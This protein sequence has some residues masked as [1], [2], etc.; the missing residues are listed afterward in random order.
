MIDERLEVAWRVAQQPV[1]VA[2][3]AGWAGLGLLV[4]AFI[5]GFRT[6][7]RA[8]VKA[9]AVLVAASAALVCLVVWQP[10]R[11]PPEDIM[12]VNQ[13]AANPEVMRDRP[14]RIYGNVACGS[15]DRGPGADDYQFK[16]QALGLL[17]DVVLEVRYVGTLPN[18]FRE[19][20]LVEA[21]GKL[22]ADGVFDV[23][24]DGIA[25]DS[26]AYSTPLHCAP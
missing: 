2:I 16:I 12:S 17:A 3:I 13:V 22:A 20:K 6:D 4:A 11:E 18:G 15:V 21:R 19:G 8:G 9:A 7:W 25:V 14:V 5:V 24:E 10:A 23:F 1:P 26:C